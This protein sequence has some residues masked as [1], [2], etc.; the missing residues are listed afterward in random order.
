VAERRLFGLTLSPL[1]ANCPLSSYAVYRSAFDHLLCR[2]ARG[3]E[4]T[5][6]LEDGYRFSVLYLPL[7]WADAYAGRSSL[8]IRLPRTSSNH[9]EPKRWW[10]VACL[11]R[12]LV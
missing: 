11:S 12:S 9:E 3:I 10:G 4:M 5:E 2:V 7:R 6:Y 1:L 8:D